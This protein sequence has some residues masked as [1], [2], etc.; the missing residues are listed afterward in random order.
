MADRL[1]S[2][3][4]A[5]PPGTGLPAGLAELVDPGTPRPLDGAASG[6]TGVL[7]G[8]ARVHGY[9]VAYYATD[10]TRRGGALTAAGCDRI[11]DAIRL[12]AGRGWPVIGV[13]HSG[14]AALHEGVASL[15]GVARMFRAMTVASGR[16]PQISLVTGPAAGGAAYGPALTD[17]VVMTR[18]A[19][20]FVTGPAVVGQ[21]TGQWLAADQLG[22][23]ELH[24]RS[25]GVAHVVAADAKQAATRVAELVTVLAAQGA[26][27]PG[28]AAADGREPGRRLP[29][30]P[31][32][33]YDV[34]PLIAELLDHDPGVLPV[35][36]RWAP[37]VVTAFGRLAG[38]TVGV[39]AN[40]PLRRG[41][42]LDARAGDKAARFVRLCDAHGVPLLVLVDVP[43]YLPGLDEER[44]G[45]VRRGAKL[46]HA[47]AAATVPRV[48]VITRKAYGGAY[49]AMNCK[50]IGATAVL[51][52]PSAEIG[53]MNADSAVDIVHRRELAAR[54]DPADRAALR[55]RLVEAYRRDACGAGGLAQ[56]VRTGAVDRVIE[57]AA[58]RAEVAAVLAGCPATASHVPNIPL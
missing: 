15:D 49:I 38:R 22:G 20:V 31:R 8:E 40:N 11:V 36:E 54:A 52:W 12:G 37:N 7:A 33:A 56:A 34:R 57:P 46:L 4:S 13:W 2:T 28:A 26:V 51:A 10:G 50:E 30:S 5:A 44:G 17:L 45:V 35:H 21:V 29:A 41:G 1:L 58:T 14:G 23:P 48:T 43:G 3:R 53:V 27:D 9:P 6:E 47:F 18:E 32:R 25:S 24:G 16:V 39:I 42:C 55:L 19:R